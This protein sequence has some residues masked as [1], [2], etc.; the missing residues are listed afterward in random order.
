MPNFD[1]WRVTVSTGFLDINE[2]Y[3]PLDS[4]LCKDTRPLH[5]MPFYLKISKL[6]H[7]LGRTTE[8][9]SRM[10][11]W[12]SAWFLASFGSPP[13]ELLTMKGNQ[14]F[15][16]ESP[17]VNLHDKS[18]HFVLASLFLIHQLK[19]WDPKIIFIL[20]ADSSLE[21]S[22]SGLHF[23]CRTTE[24][25]FFVVEIFVQRIY[26]MHIGSDLV[27][28]DVGAN[29]G[30]ASLFFA[31]KTEVSRVYAYELFPATSALAR[32]N[33]ERNRP[34]SDKVVLETKGLSDYSGCLELDYNSDK[35]GHAG[36]FGILGETSRSIVKQKQSVEVE[37]ISV[38]VKR[39]INQHTL[40]N[41]LIKL[42]CEGAE[43]A[44]LEHLQRTG[45]LES[46]HALVMEWHQHGAQPL[47]KILIACG[48]AVWSEDS[49]LGTHGMIYAVRQPKL[50]T[51]LPT[52]S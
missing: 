52:L 14:I 47:T 38:I 12:R 33:M 46:I 24:E 1:S 35:K 5:L 20:T 44:I 15:L 27:I 45:L 36:L 4:I 25:L 51:K 11:T 43:Y 34:I 2:P 16:R 49:P 8:L 37:D 19:L 31:S 21:F 32:L 30:T 7:R 13:V 18:N 39:I 29:V 10:G 6:L 42:D 3:Y 50:E 26:D 28:L 40:Q 23:Q 17:G 22:F 9:R 41:L 48:F